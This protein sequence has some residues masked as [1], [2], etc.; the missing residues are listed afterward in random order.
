MD[1]SDRIDILRAHHDRGYFRTLL[2]YG[3][4]PDKLAMYGARKE[5]AER[6]L[7]AL[8]P[9]VEHPQYP[10]EDDCNAQYDAGVQAAQQERGSAPIRRRC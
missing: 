10:T 3:D 4:S 6:T 7:D 2:Q 5:A 1:D 9:L 8:E